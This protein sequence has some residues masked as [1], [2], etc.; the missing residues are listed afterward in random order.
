MK[1]ILI[2]LGVIV[3]IAAVVVVIGYALPVKHVAARQA[4]LRQSPDR[5]FGLI[6]NV[7]DFPAW[8]PSVTRVEVLPPNNGR[9]RFKEIG[10]DGSILF[11]TDSVVP[12][13]RLVNRIADHRCLSAV[14]GF[15]RSRRTAMERSSPSPRKEKSTTRYFDSCRDLSW[16]TPGPSTATSPTCSARRR[17]SRAVSYHIKAYSCHLVLIRAKSFGEHGIPA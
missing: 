7:N 16:A 6:T 11:E 2:V 15:M 12:G 13:K 10:S 17:A 3:A 9:T 14:V 1:W 5:V 4:H 8:R